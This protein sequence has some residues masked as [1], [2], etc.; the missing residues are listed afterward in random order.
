MASKET[1]ELPS[2]TAEATEETNQTV[3]DSTQIRR[4][5]L[6]EVYKD[7][8]SE[9]YQT[10]ANSILTY[11]IYA[12]QRFYSGDYQNALTYINMASN[13]K[14]NADVLALKGSIYLG[15]G[16]TDNFVANWRQALELDP[17]VP[18]PPSPYIIQQ[19][20]QNGLIDQ[21]MKKSF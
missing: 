1:E 13:I 11:Y 7:E 21:N 5:A 3:L 8:L 18:I 16:L 2:V 17:E 20:Q 14:E 9:I 12:Q 10:E 6:L 4:E 15:L 19:L